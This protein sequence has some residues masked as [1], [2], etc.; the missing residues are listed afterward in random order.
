MHRAAQ[1]YRHGPA[2]AAVCAGRGTLLW[3]KE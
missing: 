2:D 1:L 3:E